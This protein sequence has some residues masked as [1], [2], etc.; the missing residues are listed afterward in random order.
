MLCRTTQLSPPKTAALG[1]PKFLEDI[2]CLGRRKGYSFSKRIQRQKSQ[3]FP[4]LPV[5]SKEPKY[6][7]GACS[8]TDSAGLGWPEG[9]HFSPA[10][11]GFSVCGSR[12]TLSVETQ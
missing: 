2:G 6:H 11:S 4:C 10:P 9:L 8:A 5:F 1:I 3:L 7:L 12:T